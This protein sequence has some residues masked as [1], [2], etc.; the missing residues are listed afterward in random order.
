MTFDPVS[1]KSS[2]SADSVHRQARK[3]SGRLLFR[4]LCLAVVWASIWIPY[5]LAEEHEQVGSTGTV[6]YLDNTHFIFSNED[7]LS[8][9][10]ESLLEQQAPHLLPFADAIM[11][12]SA[13]QTISPRLTLALIELESGLLSADDP[14]A[15]ALQ[16]PFGELS[17]KDS[18]I[19][20]G[21]SIQPW[22]DWLCQFCFIAFV[23]EGN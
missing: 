22:C 5:A 11:C 6:A 16:R 4:V 15:E 18:F 23:D 3:L 14:S 12:E 1:R 20:Q 21:I 17:D 13:R 8:F 7:K 10:L 19:T 2:D 9:D